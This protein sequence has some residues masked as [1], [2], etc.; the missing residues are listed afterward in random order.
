MPEQTGL[1]LGVNTN[2]DWSDDQNFITDAEPPPSVDGTP[3][4]STDGV[5][6]YEIWDTATLF[7]YR[8]ESATKAK[9]EQTGVRNLF[10]SVSFIK[11][12]FSINNAIGALSQSNPFN[13]VYGTGTYPAG[14]SIVETAKQWIGVPY[15]WA[16]ETRAGVDC[17]GLVMKVFQA[18]GVQLPHSSIAQS[19]MGEKI[20]IGAQQPGDLVFFGNPVHHVGI[21]IGNDEFIHA[22]RT[23][24]SVKISKL[25]SRKDLTHVRRIP[26][27]TFNVSS[28]TSP[29]SGKASGKASGSSSSSV[30]SSTPAK[31]M[32]GGDFQVNYNDINL[33]VAEVSVK[34]KISVHDATRYMQYIGMGIPR[35]RLPSKDVGLSISQIMEKYDCSEVVAE[36]YVWDLYFY[37]KHRMKSLYD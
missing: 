17:S 24:E 19:K 14:A 34:Y 2:K 33:S 9:F 26:V 15:K 32:W 6:L 35:G 10:D 21:Y 28:S 25:S 3:G 22:P 1:I 4:V 31:N 29:N 36:K 18:H 13:A 5:E 11:S 23:G 30:K 8:M 20:A 16:G 12:I 27:T 7:G 37:W